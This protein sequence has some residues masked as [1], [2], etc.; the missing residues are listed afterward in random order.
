MIHSIDGGN[1][2]IMGKDEGSE[3]E[4]LKGKW[5]SSSDSSYVLS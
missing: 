4:S 1:D 3:N 2:L 5:S